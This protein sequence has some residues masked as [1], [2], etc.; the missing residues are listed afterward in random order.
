MS[1]LPTH[2]DIG[3]GRGQLLVRDR[4]LVE[5]ASMFR[6]KGYGH[7][8]TRELAERVGLQKAS[9]YHHMVTK[10]SLLFDICTSALKRIGDSVE[11]AVKDQTEPAVRLRTAVMAHVRSALQD[12][13]MHATMLIEMRSLSPQH[14]EIVHGARSQYEEMVRGF[15]QEAQGARELRRDVESK[16]MTLSLLNLLNWTIFWYH[17]GAGVTPEELGEILFDIYL[18]GTG[19]RT[20]FESDVIVRRGA[21]KAGD[22][23]G[24]SAAR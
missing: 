4:L 10:E 18:N 17:S 16:W 5:A 9:L 15:V 23:R 13:D 14:Y 21:A 22:G 11:E 19:A 2:P 20:P 1:P 6:Y 3:N 24:R 7:T 8:T 12:A